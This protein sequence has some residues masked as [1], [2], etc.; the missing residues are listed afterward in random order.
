M[1]QRVTE[2]DALRAIN[3][4]ER[5]LQTVAMDQTTKKVDIGVLYNKPISEKGLRE[6]ALEVFK[7]TLRG[8]K[9]TR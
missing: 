3:L 4:V 8:I 7:K 9:A 5:M 1:H 6:T 2:D